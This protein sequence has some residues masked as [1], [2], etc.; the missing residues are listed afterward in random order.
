[1]QQRLDPI[2]SDAVVIGA[3][4]AGLAVAACLQRA[5]IVPVVLEQAGCVGNAWHGHY[6]RL[7]LHTPK[8]LSALPF[9]PFSRALPRYPSRAQVIEYLERYASD[10]HIAP[11]FGQRV[12]KA[13]RVD[14]QWSIETADAHYRSPVLVVA[15]GL[16]RQ[17]HDPQWP[18]REEF[19][20]TVLHSCAY[21]N[22]APFAG[23][24]VLVIGAG[25]SGAEIALDLHEHGARTTL[26]VRNP[27]NVVPRELFGIP[28]LAI[29]IAQAWL[30]AAWA[31]AL[32]APVLRLALGDL[33]HA[34]LKRPHAGPLTQLQ[35]HGRV[36]L[37][38]VGTIGAIRRGAIR[39][40]PG[41]DAFTADG[42]RFLDGTTAVFDAVILATGYRACVD[43]F[44]EHGGACDADGTP[45]SSGVDSGVPDLYFCG[46]HVSPTG[47]LRAI[48]NEAR[49]IARAI[50]RRRYAAA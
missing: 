20:G 30:P 21:R 39:V 27:I 42:V 29:G 10:N 15:T 6:E 33:E 22:G 4:P 7:H 44:L 48:A 49:A 37:I 2:R 5:G 43:A 34:G 50:V 32:N 9:V 31:D 28:I 16:A 26:A 36:P 17:P 46:F 14:G 1:M 41:I 11:R 23:K 47:M 12:L 19:S 13:R 35:R 24:D 45:R 40:R 38:D 18:G 3:G 25:N 8:S